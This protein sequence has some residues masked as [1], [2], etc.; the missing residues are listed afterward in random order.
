M[1]S[2]ADHMTQDV[3]SFY[4][5]SH[6]TCSSYASTLSL[7]S[8]HTFVNMETLLMHTLVCRSVAKGLWFSSVVLYI[9]VLQKPLL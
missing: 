5:T 8:G 1:Q 2:N 6:Q 4:V 9:V 3:I 7:Y